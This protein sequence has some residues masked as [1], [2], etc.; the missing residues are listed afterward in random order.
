MNLNKKEQY[1][2]LFVM[3]LL[4]AGR[5][6]IEDVSLNLNIPKSFLEQIARTLRVKGYITSVRGPGGGYE[7]VSKEITFYDILHG[8]GVS[9]DLLPSKDV[10]V[11]R[12]GPTEERALAAFA[13]AYDRKV[14]SYL[15]IKLNDVL[16]LLV[17]EEMKVLNSV[18]DKGP[19]Q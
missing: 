12:F 17:E 8:L 4:R 13:D 5:A 3:Y 15:D 18:T 10:G 1:A 16:N 19:I 14:Y 9:S 7:L 6:K 11:Y 2:I